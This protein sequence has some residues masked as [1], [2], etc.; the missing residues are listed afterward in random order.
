MGKWRGVFG[1]RQISPLE[2]TDSPVVN[3][4]SNPTFLWSQKCVYAQGSSCP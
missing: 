2:A 1:T 4:Q 3:T